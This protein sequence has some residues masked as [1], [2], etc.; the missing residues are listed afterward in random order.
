MQAGR[1]KITISLLKET[2]MDSKEDGF[3]GVE[4]GTVTRFFPQAQC[5]GIK[6]KEGKSIK[7]GDALLFKKD[8]G[9]YPIEHR[10]VITS[11]QVNGETQSRVC[12]NEP[13]I[14]AVR[15]NLPP[16]EIPRRG[17]KVFS[18]TPVIR[19]PRYKPFGGP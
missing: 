4:V 1:E 12:C 19:Q 11:I 5:V 14:P 3:S 17:T 18:C 7:T 15:L 2:V 16:E 10:Q 8:G 13:A 9:K 6:L